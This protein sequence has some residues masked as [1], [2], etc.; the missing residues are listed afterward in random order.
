M[1]MKLIM[2]AGVLCLFLG[3]IAP[4]YAQREQPEKEPG[5]PQQGQQHPQEKAAPQQHQQPG[6]PQQGQPRPQAKA[7]QQQHQQPATKPA[8]RPQQSFGGVYHGGVQPS[9][10]THAGVH[11][12]G[13]PQHQAQVRS[14]FVQSRATS[15]N[16]EHR[17][18]GQRGGY[19]GYRV[20]EDRFKLYFGNDHFF[21]INTLPM[22]F[23]GGY[24][25]FQYDGYSVTF[26]DPWPE[27]WAPTWYET[28]DVYIDY[29]NDGYYVYDRVHPGIG[30]A[31]TLSS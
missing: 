27:A 28:D 19:S 15:W 18:W 9:T 7:A 25:R 13:V 20:P 29:T 2:S 22:V 24:P 10:V 8:Q 3:T 17:S 23:V 14:G 31:V 4:A 6:T 5:K 26:V 30:I 1:P 12:S 21:R 16:S 11:P